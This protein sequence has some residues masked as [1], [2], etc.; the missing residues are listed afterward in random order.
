MSVEY[1]NIG[2]TNNLSEIYVK[3]S[4]GGWYCGLFL[5]RVVGQCLLHVSNQQQQHHDAN[6]K[7]KKL[8][9]CNAERPNQR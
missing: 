7:P 6:N 5:G 9:Q 2:S 4:A 3:V 1:I 8:M